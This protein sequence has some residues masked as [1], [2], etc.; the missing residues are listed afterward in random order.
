M[1]SEIK[2][3]DISDNLLIL[4]K[5]TIEILFKLDNCSDCIALYIFYYKTA[6]WQKTNVIKATDNYVELS[7]NWSHNRL[8]KIKTILKEKGLI[9]II[10]R[11]K[12]GKI[13]GWYVQVNYLIND[14]T[15]GE[16]T[17]KIDESKKLNS[18][19]VEISTSCN[20][21][22]N[23]Y[24]EYIICLKKEI[25]MLKRKIKENEPLNE[26]TKKET[27]GKYGRV[28]L[29][30]SEYLKLRDEFGE[31]FIKNQIDLL[32]E[33]LEI[34]NNKNKYTNFNLVLRKSIRENW[35]KDKKTGKK[36]NNVFLDIIKEDYEGVR[37]DN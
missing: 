15:F 5:M 25:E 27:Y 18:Q 30:I 33:Y 6:K 37:K 36:G 11:R 28:K 22:T 16:N 9:N 31:E 23:A 3:N 4:N 12:D 1:G 8:L 21:E 19:Q 26:D 17:I 7:M 24:K 20:Q 10:Q 35:F 2:L 29:K 32:D 34:N 14:K 13:Q